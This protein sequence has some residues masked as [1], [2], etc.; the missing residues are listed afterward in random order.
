MSSTGEP[1]TWARAGRHDTEQVRRLLTS[2]IAPVMRK[3]QPLQREDV[4]RLRAELVRIENEVFGLQPRRGS[5]QGARSLILQHLRERVGVAVTGAELR[6][7]SGIQEWARRVR[8]LRT[9]EGY[10]IAESD[11][12]YTLLEAEP[13][14]AAA[15]KWSE[16]HAIRA[17]SGGA[18]GRIERLFLARI[19]EIVTLEELH[20]VAK[21][22]EVSRRVRELR[23]EAGL[24]I[25]SQHDRP[26]LRPDEYVL[27]TKERLSPN[28]RQ[29]APATREAIL[30]RDRYSCVKCGRVPA[31]GVW[32][33][34]DHLLERSAGGGDEPA[35][36]QTLC[37]SCH[38]AKT[39][40]HLETRRKQRRRG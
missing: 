8:E 6:E 21:T 22:R 27:E 30:K 5:G 23:D 26:D 7:V 37:N 38:S 15:A 19:G 31:P 24:R 4:R 10:R 9:E 13:D 11:G 16:L 1:P 25:S 17:G 18:R 29:V 39:G 36:L 33:E 2:A 34:I 14:A 35:N 32:L 28:E 12:T 40:R 3:G 20:Y